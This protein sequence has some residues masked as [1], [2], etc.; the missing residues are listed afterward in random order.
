MKGK[1]EC[2]VNRFSILVSENLSRYIKEPIAP[3]HGTTCDIPQLAVPRG[4]GMAGCKAAHA[5][6]VLRSPAHFLPT[7]AA[8]QAALIVSCVG[9]HGMGIH[10]AVIEH[11]T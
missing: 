4:R 11:R 6:V 3:P 2:C 10:L 7:Q 9:V 1:E 5:S 8:P